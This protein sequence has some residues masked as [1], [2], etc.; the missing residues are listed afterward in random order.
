MNIF[1][2]RNSQ[3]HEIEIEK[4]MPLIYYC[5]AHVSCSKSLALFRVKECFWPSTVFM[6]VESFQKYEMGLEKGQW[7]LRIL[8]FTVLMHCTGERGPARKR[9][10]LFTR[11]RRRRWG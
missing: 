11:R 8:Q 10:V 3:N 5:N 6:R 7:F 9:K 1:R 2:A 4:G